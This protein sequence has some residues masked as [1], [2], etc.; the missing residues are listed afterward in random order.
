M[1]E[2]ETFA[3][4]LYQCLKYMLSPSRR[5]RCQAPFRASAWGKGTNLAKAEV[6]Q[7]SAM[8]DQPTK[9]GHFLSSEHGGLSGV[10]NT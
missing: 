6:H 10:A 4:L 8:A 9:G 2:Q 7:I 3:N 5:Q 1:G